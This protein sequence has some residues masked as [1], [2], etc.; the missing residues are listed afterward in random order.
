MERIET[1]NELRNEQTWCQK[2]TRNSRPSLRV[3]FWTTEQL[4]C[5]SNGGQDAESVCSVPV[6]MITSSEMIRKLQSWKPA[7]IYSRDIRF[8][9]GGVTQSRSC[10]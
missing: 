7:T 8:F 6:E 3:T 1:G 10:I 5:D 4:K 2:D 9:G